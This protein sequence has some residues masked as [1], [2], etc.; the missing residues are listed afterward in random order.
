METRDPSAFLYRLSTKSLLVLVFYRLYPTHL[1]VSDTWMPS[2]LID[3]IDVFI[4]FDIY[5]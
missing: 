5:N 1:I 2:R 3:V 4:C